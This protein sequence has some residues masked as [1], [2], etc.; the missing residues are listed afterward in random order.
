MVTLNVN[1]Q[2]DRNGKSAIEEVT[3]PD[4]VPVSQHKFAVAM[5]LR[6]KHKNPDIC[7]ITFIKKG[8]QMIATEC[9]LPDDADLETVAAGY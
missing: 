7:N 1:Y 2:I 5:K 8:R 9:G 4:S 6:A 3:I